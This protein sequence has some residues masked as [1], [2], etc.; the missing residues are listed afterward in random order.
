[1]WVQFNS[2]SINMDHCGTI[3]VTEN[4]VRFSV[5]PEGASVT[6]GTDVPEDVLTAI[7][8]ALSA[9]GQPWLDLR[10]LELAKR[11]QGR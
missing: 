10:R 4:S 6:V 5:P 2:V 8:G 7:R 1:M 3:A 11:P 9:G